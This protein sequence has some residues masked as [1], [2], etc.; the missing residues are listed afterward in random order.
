M[1]DRPHADRPSAVASALS[2][3]TRP[4]FLG[5]LRVPIIW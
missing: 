3:C 4:A 2:P 5:E 1:Q